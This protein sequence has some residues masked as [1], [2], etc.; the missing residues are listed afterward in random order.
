MKLHSA[1]PRFLFSCG[2]DTT[3]LSW[4]FHRGGRPRDSVEYDMHAIGGASSSSNGRIIHEQAAMLHVEAVASS[5]L[6]WNAVDVHAES[7]TLIAGSDAQTILLV[8]NASKV[9]QHFL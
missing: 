9:Q 7:D 2:D 6:P 3:V 1:A 4:D 8:Q 5:Y